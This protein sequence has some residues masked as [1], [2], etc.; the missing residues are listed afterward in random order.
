MSFAFIQDVPIDE[1][2][3]AEVRSEI[4]PDLPRGLSAHLVIRHGGGLRYIDVWETEADWERF[5]ERAGRSC[6]AT[7]DGEARS[8]A[9]DH[10]PRQGGD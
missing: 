4:G 9:A 2:Q 1:H 3:Y 6:R 5:R 8:H 7:D 10:P